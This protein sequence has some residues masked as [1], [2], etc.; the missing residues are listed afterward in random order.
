M[1]CVLSALKL[2]SIRFICLL[3]PYFPIIAL[4]SCSLGQSYMHWI[5][6]SESPHFSRSFMFTQAAIVFKFQ[7]RVRAR[8][9]S[10]ACQNQTLVNEKSV[11][12]LSDAPCW[13]SSLRQGG[14][15]PCSSGTY[16]R[17]QGVNKIARRSTR[18]G[19]LEIRNLYN[20]G[21]LSSPI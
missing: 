1:A 2:V 20:Q 7:L 10:E 3:L 15:L 12:R 4:V 17:Q 8:S 11:A 19:S 21:N 14:I 13:P 18:S 6:H 5:G 9:L 16:C